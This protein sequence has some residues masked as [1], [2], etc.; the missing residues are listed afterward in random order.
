M[1]SASSG[2]PLKKA[3]LHAD[4]KKIIIFKSGNSD[5][6][7]LHLLSDKM[8]QTQCSVRNIASAN[9]REDGGSKHL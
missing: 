1:I 7:T 6:R 4:P 3:P 9:F 5:F 2:T 8:V